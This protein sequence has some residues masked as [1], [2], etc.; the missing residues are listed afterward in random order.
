MS[1]IPSEV[2]VANSPSPLVTLLDPVSHIVLVT[3]LALYWAVFSLD[4][5]ADNEPW[6]RNTRYYWRP[7]V[8]IILASHGNHNQTLPTLPSSSLRWRHRAP[9]GGGP[10]SVCCT[11]GYNNKH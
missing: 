6:E 10:G 11:S 3:S 1:N 5:L 8:T 9:P 7:L 2:I 4:K